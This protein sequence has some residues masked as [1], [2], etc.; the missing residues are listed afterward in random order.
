M[1][2]EFLDD[3]DIKQTAIVGMTSKHKILEDPHIRRIVA[4]LNKKANCEVLAVTSIEYV[5]RCK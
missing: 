4:K 3:E 5:R 1:H 2:I